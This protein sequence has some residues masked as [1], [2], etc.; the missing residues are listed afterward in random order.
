[1]AAI[2]NRAYKTEDFLLGK[3]WEKPIVE[4]AMEILEVEFTPLSDARAEAVGRKL[5]AKNLL[6]KF[7]LFTQGV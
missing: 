5:L 6:L 7:Y 2:T 1:M 3:V 4:E